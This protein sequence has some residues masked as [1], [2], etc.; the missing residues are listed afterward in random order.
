MSNATTATDQQNKLQK[1]GLAGGPL[2][3]E[4]L[5]VKQ[6]D[7]SHFRGKR[8]W[9]V[10]TVHKGK[11]TGANIYGDKFGAR[12]NPERYRSEFTEEKVG[13]WLGKGYHEATEEEWAE[14]EGL[15]MIARAKK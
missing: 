2:L 8:S 7:S 1:Y 15:G 5:F 14:L 11:A 13:K 9:A 12:Y 6:L 4:R 10:M 3:A